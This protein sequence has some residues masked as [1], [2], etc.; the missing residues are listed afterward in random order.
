MYQRARTGSA[1]MSIIVRLICEDRRR[2]REQAT[3]LLPAP[4]PVRRG[5]WRRF[6]G[7]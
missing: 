1:M 4:A 2:W 7:K 5:W 6:T 3:R